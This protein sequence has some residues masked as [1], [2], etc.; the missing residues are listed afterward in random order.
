MTTEIVGATAWPN[1]GINLDTSLVITLIGCFNI[2][3]LN[4]AIATALAA[5]SV[6]LPPNTATRLMVIAVMVTRSVATPKPGTGIAFP[7]AA[8]AACE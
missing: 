5:S 1:N 8:A 7:A 4:D 6:R 3:F 2:A